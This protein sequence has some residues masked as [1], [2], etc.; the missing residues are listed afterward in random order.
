MKQAAWLPGWP[1]Q[2]LSVEGHRPAGCHAFVLGSGN[3]WRRDDEAGGAEW[4]EKERIC[5]KVGMNGH[6][7]C[8]CLLYICYSI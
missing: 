7:S 5:S 2:G 1:G 6:M 4:G 3:R 8:S